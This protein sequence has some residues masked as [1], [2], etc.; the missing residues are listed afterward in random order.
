MAM[1]STENEAARSPL[2][3]RIIMLGVRRG[4]EKLVV[5]PRKPSEVGWLRTRPSAGRV[6]TQAVTYNKRVRSGH[7][8]GISFCLWFCECVFSVA[9]YGI[10]NDIFFDFTIADCAHAIQKGRGGAKRD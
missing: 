9:L 3:V 4:R 2:P 6:A 7:E 5:A 1:F 10:R 8:G